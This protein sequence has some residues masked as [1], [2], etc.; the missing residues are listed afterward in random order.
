MEGHEGSLTSK[1]AVTEVPCLPGVGLPRYPVPL[2]ASSGKH[3]LGTQ[4]TMDFMAQQL[5]LCLLQLEVGRGVLLLFKN[6]LK[7]K[8]TKTVYGSKKKKI[9]Y[10]YIS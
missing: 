3:D 10:W 6:C 8:T 2:K 4:V 1:V 5:E 9:K 7:K